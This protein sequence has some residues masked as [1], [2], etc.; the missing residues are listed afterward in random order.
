MA[1][2]I[3]QGNNSYAIYDQTAP[4]TSEN[5]ATV[6]G[7]FKIVS[8]NLND[9][10][11]CNLYKR[12][13]NNTVHEGMDFRYNGGVFKLRVTNS[14]ADNDSGPTTISVNKWYFAAFVRSGNVRDVYVGDENNAIGSSPEASINN[15]ATVGTIYDYIITNSS[16][17]FSTGA[18]QYVRAFN[19]TLT[20]NQIEAERL[21]TSANMAA[22]RDTPL[23]D[24]SNLNDISGNG[25][26][27]YSA[28][29]VSN[30]TGPN[31]SGGITISQSAFR[32]RNDDG[33]EANATWAANE[34]TA[35]TA[36]ANATRRLRFQVDTTG[37]ANATPF[38]LEG[39]PYGEN[40]W[41]KLT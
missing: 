40:S 23:P 14:M 21:R 38:Q 2:S 27:W 5:N 37:D 35:I 39:S 13:G 30:A 12:Q 29:T 18:A 4:L 36:P 28:G 8:H 15:A 9:M 26:N 19:S 10:E 24:S 34:N 33:N 20:R 7:W 25:R 22:W 16:N 11:V 3:P 32:V 1:V 41:V 31:L 17:H 6:T